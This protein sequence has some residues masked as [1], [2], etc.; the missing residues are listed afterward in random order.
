MRPDDLLN[1]YRRDPRTGTILGA[2]ENLGTKIELKGVVG[3]SLALIAAGVFERE[4]ENV[5][6]KGGAFRHHV[7]VLDDKEQAAYFMNDLEQVLV[8][9]PRPT[10]LFPRSARVPY[11]EEVTENANIAMRAEVLNEING[12]REGCVIVSY[13]GALSEQVITKKELSAQTFLI[14]V[15]DNFTLDFLDEV[16]LEYGFEK[17]DF[18]YEPGQ[19]AMRGGIV[20]VFSF[21]FDHPYRIE[22]FGEEI[23]SIR[24]FDPVS[25]L[26]VNKL[27]R[28]TIVPNVGSNTSKTFHEEQEPFFSFIPSKSVVWM[29]DVLS[30]ELGLEK[31]L[32]KATAHYE[33]LVGETKRTPPNELYLDPKIF[34]GII[35]DFSVIEFRGGKSFPERT[36]VEYGMT[37]QPAFNKHF[38]MIATNLIANNR[39]GYVNVIVSGQATQLERLHDIFSDRQDENGEKSPDV[40]YT[41][42]PMELSEGFVD[43]A[44]K[45]L[46]YTDHQLF[47]R[48]HRFRLKDGFRKSK[49]AL[50]IKE[51][52]ALEV[53]DFVVHIDHG[54]GEFSG[55]HK[56][57]VNGKE[58]EAIRL[59][60]KGGDVL[61]VSIHSLHRISKFTSKEGTKPSVNK[62]GT[63]TWA[64]TKAKTKSRV[65]QIAYDL[66]QLYAKRKAAEGFAFTPDSYLQHE[67]EASFMFEDTPDQHTAT[68]AVKEDMEK[69]VPMDRLICG[70]VGFGKTEVA[71]R[72]AFKAATD[73]KQVAMLVPTT[74]LSMQHARSFSRRLQDFPV[75]VDYINRFKTGKALSET[76]SKV[77][78]GEVD[79]LIG[80]H[81]IVGKRVEFKDL[82]LL[83]VDEE[84]KF[85]VGV[86]D[87]LK[88]LRENVDTLTL[89][90]TPIPRTLQFSLMGA[91][92]LSIIRTAPPNRHPVETILTSFNEEM[93]RDAISYEVSR[94]GQVYFVH[95]RVANIKDVAGIIQRLC[96]DVRVGI[97]H[98]QMEGKALENVMAVF[99][100]GG[101]D[102]LIATTIIESGIDIS[103]A[104]TILINDAHKFGLSDLHQ[105]RGRVGRSNRKAFCY[106]MSPPLSSLPEESRKRLQALEQFSD[107]GS[108]VQI[109]MR[110]LDIRGAGD[111][112]G[113]E[114]SGFISDIGFDM[115]QRI[116]ADAV[117]ELKE[118]QFN[119][120]FEEERRETG[121]YVEE[122]ILETDF[123]ILIPD[124]Y[125]S[126]I[127]ERITLYRELDGLD[128]EHD[129]EGFKVKLEDRFGPMPN[130]TIELLMTMR[131]R[132]VSRILGMEKVIL[133]SGKLIAAFVS[134]EKSPYF[135]GPMF[136][137]VLNYL[138]HNTKNTSM[139]QRNGALRLRIENVNS[140]RLA[141][142]IF[143]DMAGMTASEAADMTSGRKAAEEARKRSKTY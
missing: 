142:G 3:S 132:W 18:V 120:L 54:I 89:T 60:Y 90:A 59:S 117:R 123:S 41:P 76:L 10:F 33:R 51:L 75:K 125:I 69:V 27:T 28:A 6:E 5:L 77:K 109:A 141:L 134:E 86:K 12:G 48:Y 37:E 130:E 136:A 85:G 87:K 72:A 137:R 62:L 49:E 8:E 45:V 13:P 44:L 83:I 131:F 65:K 17:V 42:I 81:A 19:Y 118:E 138:K 139:Y 22:F 129:L 26:S 74:I 95:N 67:L 70:D 140:I 29:N 57:E 24:K 94:G 40:P 25:Q 79:I 2:L 119:E 113:A 121:K 73:G 143:E 47:D 99:I 127:P 39:N 97:G 101:Y 32:E 107:L 61:Y 105:L 20:D 126:D 71:I 135:Q 23:E 104:N 55:L 124:H 103:N 78:S 112:L 46:V 7:F 56:I 88:T 15:G 35:A 14:N 133:K 64:K 63:A 108:G 92:D 16:F 110:D 116:L 115:Y 91:R 38:D 9:N 4:R 82:G 58:Q 114:Q 1:F 96:P 30:C 31:E 128:T 34:K 106:L 122:T 100:E 66:L 111:L 52:M 84:Q 43:K 68:K 21:S 102:V 98:G 93:I 11:Q 36:T 80:T 53:G 50:T